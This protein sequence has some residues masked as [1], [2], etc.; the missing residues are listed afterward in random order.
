MNKVKKD[1]I[2]KLLDVE[3]EK[4]R[5]SANKTDEA[6]KVRLTGWSAAGDKYHA[7]AA[8]D[9]IKNYLKRLELLKKELEKAQDETPTKVKPPCLLGVSYDDGSVAELFLVKNAVSLA[10]TS[11]IS[12]KSP[13]G[14][15]VLGKSKDDTFSYKLDSGKKFSGKIIMIE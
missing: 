13:L 9:L 3:I 8:A 4:I 2:L 1:Q 10:S 12:V 14:K 6:S 7:M 15:A 5:E 11:F